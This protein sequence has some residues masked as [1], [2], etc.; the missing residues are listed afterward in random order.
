MC[1]SGVV[2][3]NKLN[4]TFQHLLFDTIYKGIDLVQVIEMCSIVYFTNIAE[5]TSYNLN[6]CIYINGCLTLYTIW[7]NHAFPHTHFMW[8]LNICV[9]YMCIIKK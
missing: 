8:G 7:F 3:Q 9:L 5:F 1:S 6:V 4:F 2:K